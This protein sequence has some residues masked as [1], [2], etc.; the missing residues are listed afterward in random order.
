MKLTVRR[1]VPE[2]GACEI[3]LEIY[4]EYGRMICGI[5]QLT[6][7]VALRPKAW[8]RAIR[9]EIKTI[10]TIARD[11][12]CDEIRLAGRDWSRVLPD[13]EPFKPVSNTNGLRKALT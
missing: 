3:T 10:E 12:G 1:A 13:Y 4:Q 6:G 2:V 5:D 7:H 8:L 9:D 11:A